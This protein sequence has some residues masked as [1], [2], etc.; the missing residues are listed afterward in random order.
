MNQTEDLGLAGWQFTDCRSQG[1]LKFTIRGDL[2]R[3]SGRVVQNRIQKRFCNFSLS[4]LVDCTTHRNATKESAP[5]LIRVGF[6]FAKRFGEDVLT[7][8]FRIGQIAQ[9]SKGRRQYRLGVRVDDLIPIHHS[10]LLPYTL[11]TIQ[12]REASP[13]ESPLAPTDT[14]RVEASKH[15]Q[16]TERKPKDVENVEKWSA[17]LSGQQ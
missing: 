5:V 11:V 7:D 14:D 15:Y 4:Q 10:L 9:Y 13:G 17:F 16:R 6:P 3:F 2:K 12:N 1:F 8:I